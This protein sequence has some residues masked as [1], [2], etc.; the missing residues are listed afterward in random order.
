MTRSVKVRGAK[1]KRSSPATAFE[2][3]VKNL[4]TLFLKED[5]ALPLKWLIL[6]LILIPAIA[7]GILKTK[8]GEK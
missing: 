6:S 3:T 2:R 1:T 7:V 4:S 5:L 8:G